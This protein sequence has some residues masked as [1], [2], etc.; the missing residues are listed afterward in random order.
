MLSVTLQCTEGPSPAETEPA[1]NVTVLRLTGL[2]WWDSGVSLAYHFPHHWLGFNYV[3]AGY[4]FS[5]NEFTLTVHASGAAPYLLLNKMIN[6][7]S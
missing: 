7:P 6:G 4:Y 2:L 5:M 3:T 1:P